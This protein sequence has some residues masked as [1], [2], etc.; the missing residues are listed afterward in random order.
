[1]VFKAHQ[2]LYMGLGGVRKTNCG[3]PSRKEGG[4]QLKEKGGH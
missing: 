4:L 2:F 1:M 3:R